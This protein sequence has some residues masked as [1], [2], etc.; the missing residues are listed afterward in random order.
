MFQETHGVYAQGVGQRT[1]RLPAG[2]QDR[3]IPILNE[4][5]AGVE[6]WC[7]EP[8][9]LCISKLMRDAEGGGVLR[10]LSSWGDGTRNYGR[11]SP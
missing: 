1:A 6:G 10:A 4:N 8:H 9:D 3:L 2:W 11:V 5:T 7:L